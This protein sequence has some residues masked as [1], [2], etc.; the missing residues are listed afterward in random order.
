MPTVINNPPQT[1]QNG[2]NP[3]TALITG[4]VVIVLVLIF[5]LYG[6]PRIRS[7][8]SGTQINIPSNI[9]IQTSNKP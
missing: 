7:G 6:L 8:G 2:N 3:A 9:N 1:P 4:V 5:L